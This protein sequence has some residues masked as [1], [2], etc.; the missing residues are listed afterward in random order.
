[1]GLHWQRM[2]CTSRLIFTLMLTKRTVH[3]ATTRL[4][5][6]RP[7]GCSRGPQLRA[8]V[9]HREWALD[10]AVFQRG[11][12]DRESS[13]IYWVDEMDVPVLREQSSAKD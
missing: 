5:R 11:I 9:A 3:L 1:M 2:L 7:L 12:P 4:V 10:H 8:G 13:S 6:V